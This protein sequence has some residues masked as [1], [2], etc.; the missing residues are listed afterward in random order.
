MPLSP[1]A[2]KPAPKDMLIDVARL[3]R[4]YYERKPDLADPDQRV[5][6]GTSGHRGTPLQRHLHR[7]PHP[8]HHPGHL[9]VPPRPG[10]QRPALHGQGHARP[11]R[12]GPAHRPGSAGRQRR[13]NRHPA[14]RR[15]HADAG[16]LARHP[17][18]QPRPHATTSPTASSS[19]RRTTRRRTAA[20]STTRPT[21]APPTPTSPAGSRTAPTPC[22]AAD[23]AEVKRLPYA[24]ALQGGHHAR[25]RTSSCPT[26]TTCATSS[27]WTPSAPPASSSASIRSAAPRVALLGADQRDLRPRHHRGQSEGRSDL[28]AS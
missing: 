17:R 13:R 22:C 1:L 8:R 3:E 6:F 14:R 4:D 20:S 27:T 2:G 11:L 7:S 21:A 28:L 12:P 16:H 5:T 23:N 18:L 10:H 24:T 15:R 9:R 26:S 19:R 25:S